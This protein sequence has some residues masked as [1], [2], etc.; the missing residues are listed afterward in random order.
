MKDKILLLLCVGL[1]SVLVFSGFTWRE[2]NKPLEFDNEVTIDVLY[3][4][5]IYHVATKLQNEKVLENPILWIWYARIFDLAKDIKAGEYRIS[6]GMSALQVLDHIVTANV[7]QYSV[8]LI[9][10]WTVA[11]ALK[12][13]QATPGIVN[14]LN[15]KD[16]QL[17]L[18]SVNADSR[19]SH[20]EGLFYPD[21]YQFIKGTK[22]H[23]ILKRAHLRLVSAMDKAWESRDKNLPY[24]NAYEVL[25]MASII[26][27]ETSVGSERAQI[28]GV[29]VQRLLK[30]MRLQTDPTVIYG[31]GEQYQGNI[32][33][34]DLRKPTPYNT[35]TNNGLPPTPIALPTEASLQAAVH[36]LLNGMLY[37]VAKGDG[38]HYFSKTLAEHEK[39]VREYQIAR[40]KNYRSSPE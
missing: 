28:A 25:I 21:T 30:G 15:A 17:I 12:A 36:P 27:R 11:E 8:T 33:R 37:F 24:K 40:K 32:T 23:E 26:E 14:T 18:K 4:E 1:I 5:S 3:G 7:I 35:Y 31:M 39:A 13:I 9:E 16:H 38:H 20:S 2:L 29:F 10:G 22:D 6:S 34:K 19:F